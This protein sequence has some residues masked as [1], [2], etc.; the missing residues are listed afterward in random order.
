M[1]GSRGVSQ[2]GVSADGMKTAGTNCIVLLGNCEFQGQSGLVG[3]YN[4]FSFLKTEEKIEETVEIPEQT[5]WNETQV[6][7]KEPASKAHWEI[8]SDNMAGKL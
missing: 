6:S 3:H 1:R 8:K 4:L 7:L 2:L 5:N